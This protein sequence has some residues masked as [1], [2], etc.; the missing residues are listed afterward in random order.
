MSDDDEDDDDADIRKLDEDG[1]LHCED[2]PAFISKAGSSEWWIHGKAHRLDG[3]ASIISKK[4]YKFITGKRSKKDFHYYW[5]V[6]HV[7]ITKNVDAWTKANKVS[8]PWDENTQAL[9]VLTF[10]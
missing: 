2:G 10:A 8:W 9:F 1:R 6:N 7:D 4:D 5:Y 3:P